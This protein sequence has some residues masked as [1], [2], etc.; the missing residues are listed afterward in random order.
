MSVKI[1]APVGAVIVVDES[2]SETVRA[3]HDTLRF[4]VEQGAEA[5]HVRLAREDGVRREGTRITLRPLLATS[6]L[7]IGGR[8]Y[9]GT[10]EI[11]R[12]RR[13]G[14]TVVNVLGMEEY[15]RGV[16]PSEIG[17]LS[18][19][20][21]AAV[22][23]QAIAARTYALSYLGRHKEDGFDLLPTTQDQV[24][25][26]VKGEFRSGDRALLAT[27]GI[28][29]M[30][31][32]GYIRCN[33]FSTCGGK[34]ANVEEV[35]NEPPLA[36]LR[37]QR[38]RA[39]AERESFCKISKY[40]RWR[41]VWPADEFLDLLATYGPSVFPTM[42]PV[43]PGELLAVR[44]RERGSSHR[45][46]DLEIHTRSGTYHLTGDRIRL[47][48]R[49]PGHHEQILRSTLFSVT[50]RRHNDRAVAVV[51]DGGGF[52]HGVGMCQMGAIGMARAGYRVGQIVGH[53]YEGAT[54]VRK[55]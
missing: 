8:A 14:V 27:R 42:G 45:V 38:D 22:E 34:T 54:L 49:R 33:Y 52:G 46:R 3:D 53:Y 24:Y 25:D 32:A 13:G 29:A 10:F 23:A 47:V 9:R 43:K 4:S 31:G 11:F 37:A 7:R 50:V 16:V 51:F 28:V 35:W 1:A 44:V 41:E 17:R 20:L 18:D 6:P 48:L 12:G 40:Y 36:F 21:L 30:Q 55:Y 2:A 39:G 5:E 26:G 19:T 15:L